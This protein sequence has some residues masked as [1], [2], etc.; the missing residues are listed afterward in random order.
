MIDVE[1]TVAVLQR[2]ETEPALPG[3]VAV[4][5]VLVS[6]A[7]DLAHGVQRAM[8]GPENIRTAQRNALEALLADRA[9][10]QAREDLTREIA[11]LVAARKSMSESIRL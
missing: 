9:R 2:M 1:L 5:R 7:A 3:F 4:S 6:A 10:N 11:A 8:V